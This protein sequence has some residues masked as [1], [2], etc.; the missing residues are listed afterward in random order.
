MA[1]QTAVREDAATKGAEWIMNQKSRK[2]KLTPEKLATLTA[3][4]LEWAA[5]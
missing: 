4:G 3:L 1:A 2:P 5:V